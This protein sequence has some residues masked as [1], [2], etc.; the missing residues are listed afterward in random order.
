MSPQPWGLGDPLLSVCSCAAVCVHR[1]VCTCSCECGLS[2]CLFTRLCV[3]ASVCSCASVCVHATRVCAYV[4]LCV[5]VCG[6]DTH[7][8]IQVRVCSESSRSR[9]SSRS[10]AMA[11]AS[12]HPLGEEAP[13]RCPCHMSHTDTRRGHRSQNASVS[14]LR[15]VQAAKGPM[16][17]TCLVRG[18]SVAKA[19]LKVVW[20]R[21]WL[22]GLCPAG[23]GKQASSRPWRAD[24][25][26]IVTPHLK[27][28]LHR[29]G[30]AL[31]GH[32]HWGHGAEDTDA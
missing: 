21:K 10:K 14:R 8:H 16:S 26:G 24:P 30:E 23:L 32:P 9:A 22:G 31:R 17:H 19:K 18:S 7:T 25:Q 5:P 20:G 1:C 15:L 4:L 6:V 27:Q 11:P 3:S 29:H 28:Q 12:P 2:P 13:G